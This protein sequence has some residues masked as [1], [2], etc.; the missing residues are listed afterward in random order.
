MIQDTTFIGRNH[1]LT[2]DDD[3]RENVQ[4]FALDIKTNEEIIVE[5]RISY[6]KLI[7]WSIITI[8]N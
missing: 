1:H 8:W 6:G 3:Y 2:E 5:P 4:P 7:G